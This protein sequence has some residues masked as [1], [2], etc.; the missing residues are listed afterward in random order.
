MAKKSMLARQRKRE[1]LVEKFREKRL[2]LKMK[3]DYQALDK[4][5]K[6]ASSVRLHNRCWEERCGRPRSFMRDFGLCRIHFREL[7]SQGKIP[8]ITKCSF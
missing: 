2:E 6:D 1:R 7:A 5:P 3:G 4:L 8:G